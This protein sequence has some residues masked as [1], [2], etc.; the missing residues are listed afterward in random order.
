MKVLYD[1]SVL[2]AALLVNHPNHSLAFPKLEIVQR[3]VVH[4]YLSTHSLA[5]LYSVLT[6]LPEPLR[7]FPDEAQTAIADL[8]DYFEAV[9]LLVEDYQSVI[10]QMVALNLP[11]GGVF[12]A[13]IAQAALKAEVAQLLTFNPQDFVRLGDAIAQLVQ[14]PE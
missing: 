9:P 11:G 14:V 7:V 12:D 8:I 13:V 2:V 10:A 5:E 3:R 1:T 4:G 6:R